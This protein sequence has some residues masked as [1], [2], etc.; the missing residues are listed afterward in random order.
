M[1]NK[2]TLES[3]QS[4]TGADE[5]TARCFLESSNW[6]LEAGIS[7]F[8]DHGG[9]SPAA[10]VVTASRVPSLGKS[11]H[12]QKKTLHRSGSGGDW[13]TTR[14]DV[15]EELARLKEDYQR[16]HERLAL[17]ERREREQQERE[18]EEEEARREL[19][20]EERD[21]RSAAA[22]MVPVPIDPEERRRARQAYRQLA[23]RPRDGDVGLWSNRQRERS[24]LRAGD[25]QALAHMLGLAMTNAEATRTAQ[26]L[27]TRASGGDDGEDAEQVIRGLLN[28]QDQKPGEKWSAVNPLAKLQ[29]WTTFLAQARS[30]AQASAMDGDSG[31]VTLDV[32]I[33]AG[34]P[35]S[36]QA[37]AIH[38]K[39]S[40]DATQAALW[41]EDHRAPSEDSTI[42]SFSFTTE[43]GVDSFGLGEISGALKDILAS[44]QPVLQY[45]SFQVQVKQQQPREGCSDGKEKDKAVA[46]E[47]AA[48]I[49]RLTLF[50]ADLAPV[51]E[52]AGLLLLGFEAKDLEAS[53]QFSGGI[54]NDEKTS[55]HSEESIK[56]SARVR[57]Q[58]P[59]HQLA[60]LLKALKAYR[61]AT[62]LAGGAV[63]H[64]D[65][66]D[67]DDAHIAKLVT[68]LR[69]LALR[70]EFADLADALRHYL[71]S[72][73]NDVGILHFVIVID[74]GVHGRCQ[75][76]T[77]KRACCDEADVAFAEAEPAMVGAPPPAV[78][79]YSDIV[80][81]LRALDSIHLQC[82]N[83]ALRV[84]FDNALLSFLP[85][86]AE[87][88]PVIDN[89]R[90]ARSEEA[91]RESLHS[92]N[93]RLVFMGDDTVG[94]TSYLITAAEHA[95]PL[96]APMMNENRELSLAIDGRTVC[97]SLWDSMGVDSYRRL[98][99]LAAGSTDM[100]VICFAVDDPESYA[101]VRTKWVPE[102]QTHS[103]PFIVLALKT[104]L[105]RVA[106]SSV[107][108]EEE[109]RKLAEE[110]GAQGYAE[111]SAQ[112][113][114][115]LP[116][117]ILESY[118]ARMKFLSSGPSDGAKR[119]IRT[120]GRSLSVTS[121]E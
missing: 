106:G 39:L 64:D 87:L 30:A 44:M 47:G 26:A 86:M 101:S 120:K 22:A 96:H 20:E 74:G 107:I 11:D 62:N 75:D 56:A 105:R 7:T 111:A 71:P 38:A 121:F 104:D 102:V 72:S 28:K 85:S 73:S 60:V 76:L 92:Q 59:G 93:I 109:G 46:D 58:L 67:D 51:H 45:S 24:K 12:K 88:T 63:R 82:G 90:E 61:A 115:G 81:K 83:A 70:F 3:F 54:Y 97:V 31:D 119:R 34:T 69:Q 78:A 52:L 48:R 16:L 53:L 91:A 89:L 27:A 21:N 116:M 65:D 68:K 2:E 6:N 112:D 32:D 10:A 103:K 113:M 50:F 37:A 5:A 114:S 35:P 118:R 13:P 94:K 19:E 23:G 14:D 49:F 110:V 9:V 41:R 55:V 43:E 15:K 17:Y 8:F 1:N 4:I 108:T 79:A 29:P 33:N 66:S 42:L 95:F 84:T 98:R 57:A 40:L 36:S 100:F 77:V 117:P 18:L 25:L 99:A 80:Q